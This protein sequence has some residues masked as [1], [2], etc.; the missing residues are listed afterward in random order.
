VVLGIS[1]ACFFNYQVHQVL[2]EENRNL[3]TIVITVCNGFIKSEKIILHCNLVFS[4]L[5]N[6]RNE[7]LVSAPLA[8]AYAT[9]FARWQHPAMWR[10]TRFAMPAAMCLEL[11]YSDF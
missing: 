9:K 10:E 3:T 4:N 2:W 6:P 1:V 8:Q 5:V 11:I 7:G